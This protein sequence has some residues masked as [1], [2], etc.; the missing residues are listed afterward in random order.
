MT[1]ESGSKEDLRGKVEMVFQA[2]LE[3]PNSFLKRESWMFL[4]QSIGCTEQEAK[5]LLE[6]YEKEVHH[7]SVREFLDS[8]LG[9]CQ[10]SCK[11]FENSML[12]VPSVTDE[13][14]VD[15]TNNLQVYFQTLCPH[16]RFQHHAY[17][18][19]HNT[20]HHQPT[21]I[22]VWQDAIDLTEGRGGQIYFHYTNE[23]SF[24]HITSQLESMEHV[25][26]L[27]S[28]TSHTDGTEI[29]AMLQMAMLNVYK[30]NISALLFAFPYSS[31]LAMF[32]P[33]P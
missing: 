12:E 23:V 17:L 19:E 2:A 14:D 6:D 3:E 32:S 33:R 24:Q 20:W 31:I 8:L 18:E 9:P 27:E 1:E 10:S 11:D 28:L 13:A 29:L 22:R 4:V 30:E 16:G 25:D 7:I 26:I 21:N 15:T 5:I